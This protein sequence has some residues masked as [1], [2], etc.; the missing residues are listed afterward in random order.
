MVNAVPDRSR[1]G[2]GE[3]V[4]PEHPLQLFAVVG[5]GQRD[6]GQ[7]AGFLRVQVMRHDP[8]VLVVRLFGITQDETAGVDVG[9]TNDLHAV[10]AQGLQ[11][12]DHTRGDRTVAGARM[13]DRF[14]TGLS[15]CLVGR[16]ADVAVGIGD[17][18]VRQA[19]DG[20]DVEFRI[21]GVTLGRQTEPVGFALNYHAERAPGTFECLGF[22]VDHFADVAPRLDLIIHGHQHAFAAGVFAAGDG[23]GVVQ[24]QHAVSRHCGAWAHG[25]DD[26]D[27]L[28]GFFHQ[29]QE[30]RGFFQGVGA[31]GDHDP[32][33]VFA[34]GQFGDAATQ[35][36]QVVVGDA[37]RGD[38]H[39][40][41]ATNVG[42]LAELRNPGDQLLDADFRCLVGR[43]VSSAGAGTGNG[44]AGGEDHHVGQF[45]LGFDFFC[46][47]SG[48]Q[49]QQEGQS[50]RN[51]G[52]EGR[53]HYFL[54]SSET[55][56]MQV[57]LDTPQ[58]DLNAWGLG[59]EQDLY[60][61]Y[62]E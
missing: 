6:H 34:V 15:Q 55:V 62:V 59:E 56:L 25:A 22:D 28:V 49:E 16:V 40:L 14:G 32:V 38:L 7:D 2:E 54:S 26:D 50:A 1:S 29:I 51:K 36:Q 30:V 20:F 18:D 52:V 10:L 24:V 33:D 3:S 21:H 19:L 8:V 39:D 57:H 43:A 23:D 9:R 48:R 5:L 47:K 41:F 61:P 60:Q 27:W 31:V 12:R 35:L 53:F 11:G 45:L 17:F 44:A 13:D 4:F 46:L 58:A 37:F 42:Q